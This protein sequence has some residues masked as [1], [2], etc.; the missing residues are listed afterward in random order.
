MQQLRKFDIVADVRGMGLMGCVQCSLGGDKQ[1]ELERDYDIGL[2][3]DIECQK[4][5]LLV[6]P[7]INMCVLSPPLIISES[8]IDTIFSILREGLE[9]TTAWF[10]RIS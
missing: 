5:G 6:R 1:S 7:V 8:E 10:G 4:R 3:I 9:A 2:Q